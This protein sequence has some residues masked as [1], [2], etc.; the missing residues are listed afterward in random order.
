M[1]AE[2]VNRVR[3]TDVFHALPLLVGECRPPLAPRYPS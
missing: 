2:S 3:S 1:T